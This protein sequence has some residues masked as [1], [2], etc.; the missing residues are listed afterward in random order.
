MFKGTAERLLCTQ[1]FQYECRLKPLLTVVVQRKVVLGIAEFL[2]ATSDED[3]IVT[4]EIL[5]T[6]HLRSQDTGRK[7]N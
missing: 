1:T 7:K 4:K 2:R 3:V 5:E 6:G